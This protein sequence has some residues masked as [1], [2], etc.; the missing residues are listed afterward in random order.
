MSHL[1]PDTIPQ[2]AVDFMN[3]DHQV[4]VSLINELIQLSKANESDKITDAFNRLIHH[5]VEHFSR[6]EIEM[7]QFGFPPYDCHKGEHKR[8][9]MEMQ[10][11]LDHWNATGDSEH[12]FNYLSGTLISWFH[13][14]VNTMDTVTASFIKRFQVKELETH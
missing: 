5:H 9:I 7:I 8:V 1:N 11:Q 4:S 12:L 2:V 3:D 13:N 14:H 6:E 10:G